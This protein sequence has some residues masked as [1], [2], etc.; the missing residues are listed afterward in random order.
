MSRLEAECVLINSPFL[1][2]FVVSVEKISCQLKIARFDKFLKMRKVFSHSE[3]VGKMFC[4]T[5]AFAAGEETGFGGFPGASMEGGEEGGVLGGVGANVG[6]LRETEEEGGEAIEEESEVLDGLEDSEGDWM[7]QSRMGGNLG[8]TCR[9]LTFYDPQSRSRVMDSF[10]CSVGFSANSV[11]RTL[12]PKNQSRILRFF[13]FE[14][15]SNFKFLCIFREQV[16]LDG[17]GQQ[18]MMQVVEVVNLGSNTLVFQ[19]TSTERWVITHVEIIRV[20]RT[21][22]VQLFLGAAQKEPG[23]PTL[24]SWR[25]YRVVK[26]IG[27]EGK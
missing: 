23:A 2:T 4:V 6:E 14:L 25:I 11:F 22:E 26:H 8:S 16:Q 24:A 9:F 18:K 19:E 1:E 20:A 12:L 15:D 13:S 27:M 3:M 5:D 10:L 7:V 17:E 21:G